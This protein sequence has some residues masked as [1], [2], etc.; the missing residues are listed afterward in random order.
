[1]AST[2]DHGVAE[3]LANDLV[4]DIT[5]IGRNSGEP[6]RL[7]IWFHNV[8]DRYYITGRP[9][10]RSW[11]ANVLANPAITFHFKESTEADLEGTARA[12]TNAAEKRAFFL[13]ARKLSEY[14]NED[15]VQEW[16]DGSPLIEV[17][18]AQ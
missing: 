9:G 17:V 18:F 1:M 5:T 14:I 15:N 3:A 10:P 2:S 16:V 13:T 6:K 12:V 8:D 4:I 7:E 11:Y